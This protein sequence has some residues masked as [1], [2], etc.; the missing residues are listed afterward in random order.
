MNYA[1][2]NLD[3]AHLSVLQ[4][5]M[6]LL[7]LNSQLPIKPMIVIGS[8]TPENGQSCFT[9]DNNALYGPP[10]HQQQ[11]SGDK[12]SANNHIPHLAII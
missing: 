8:N 7:L 2:N 4:I 1:V 6:L 11:A 5:S 9:E 10:L 3:L 12:R